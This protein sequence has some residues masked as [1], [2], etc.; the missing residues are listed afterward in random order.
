MSFWQVFKLSVSDQGFLEN[1]VYLSATFG[2][3][4]LLA[5]VLFL[6]IPFLFNAFK[7]SKVWKIVSAIITVLS[8]LLIWLLQTKA[9]ILSII[10]FGFVFSLVVY[11]RQKKNIRHSVF[12]IAAVAAFIFISII[13]VVTFQNR[14]KFY[15]LF[16]KKS[17]TERLF[18]WDNSVQMIKEHAVFGVGG[19]N[20]QINVP[21]YGLNNCPTPAIKE[22]I[23]TLQ[24]PHNDFLWIFCEMGIIGFLAYAG[25]FISVLYH[26]V[27]LLKK[28]ANDEYVWLYS[29]LFAGVIGYV[30]IAFVDFPL[31]RI[32]HQVL[33]LTIFSMVT[34][35]YY[36]NVQNLNRTPMLITAASFGLLLF[37]T[38]LFSATVSI[39]RSIGE[40]HS[41]KIY[42]NESKAN[43]PR[44]IAEANNAINSF[45]VI[46]PMSAPIEWYKGVALFSQGNIDDARV[47]FEKAY[48]IHPYNMHVINNLASCYE[49][50]KDH[51][52]AIK[53]YQMALHISSEFEEARLNL[54][55]VYFN[56]QQFEKAFEIIDE[57]HVNSKDPK[58]ASFLPVI[59]NAFIKTKLNEQQKEKLENKEPNSFKSM[60]ALLVH[61]Y[62]DAKAK[63]RKFDVHVLDSL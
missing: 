21:K 41:Q 2:I 14:Q 34:A 43:W 48:S 58:Y 25:I 32:E 29:T 27:K 15:H 51:E 8:L 28:H 13:G 49:S 30:M 47:S 54:S 20:W 57:C 23:Q 55:A 63:N 5:S 31:E 53:Y 1:V 11:L 7:F 12:K 42:T 37:V 62:F 36:K 59:L 52:K 60:N 33:L 35:G 3:K 46:D 18:I 44:L 19:G 4:N 61:L 50:V 26:S 45:Y 16:D 10:V 39:K 38:V 56:T 22:G 40:F 6:T 24:R 17:S 9:V